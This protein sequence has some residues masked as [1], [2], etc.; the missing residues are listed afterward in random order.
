MTFEVI[1][2]KTGEYPDLEH[3]ARTE[4]WAQNL[5]PCDMEGFCINED[6]NMLLMDECG[7]YAHCPQNRFKTALEVRAE[8]NFLD[9]SFSVQNAVNILREKL[10]KCGDL[11]DA[12]IAS[13]K[14]AI[15]E[16]PNYTSESE[17]AER[18][19]D[20]LIGIN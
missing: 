1:D 10:L 15:K 2:P 18:I 6:G 14:S 20:R 11:H 13:I 8:M 16:A 7:N 17:L 12:F 19:L 3:I 4:E 5:I 9:D